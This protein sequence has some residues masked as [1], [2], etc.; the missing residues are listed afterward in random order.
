FPR[1]TPYPRGTRPR[2]YA[3]PAA[4]SGYR[5][6]L[7][8]GR[9]DARNRKR[10]AP[11]RAGRYRSADHNYDR[12]YGSKDDYRREYRVAFER[13]YEDGFTGARL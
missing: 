12:R 9:K 10:F 4:E 13:G 5:D 8:A 6:G 1:T 3:S 2:I 7:E 11:E